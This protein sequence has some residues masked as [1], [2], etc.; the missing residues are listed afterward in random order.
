MERAERPDALIDRLA[1]AQHG[2]VGGSQLTD[3]GLSRRAIQWRAEAGRL[4]PIF[5]GVFRVG[6]VV[7]PHGREMA[8]VLACGKHAVLSHGTAG[9]IWEFAPQ[10]AGG[11]I[12]LSVPR[13]VRRRITGLVIHRS[14]H[15]NA[16]DV[17]TRAGLPLTTPRRTLLDLAAVMPVSELERA[18]ARAERAGLLRLADV[19]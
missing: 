13:A 5:R 17:T 6:P 8:A 14:R 9:A 3:A 15:L 7:L 16:T 18:A 11:A 1:S 12:E 4:H 19:V 2:V 10:P